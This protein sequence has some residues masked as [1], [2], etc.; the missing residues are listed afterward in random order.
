MVGVD[1]ALALTVEGGGALTLDEWEARS[2]TVA[3]GLA[4]GSRVGLLF[5]ARHWSD[6]AVAWLGVR[7][8]GAV[9]VLFSPGAAAPDLARAVAH[10]GLTRLIRAEEL[11]EIE[12]GR[13]RHIP[14]EV[15]ID[16]PD[17]VVYLLAPLAP[18]APVGVAG[19]AA[20]GGGLVHAWAPGSVGS[21]LA[22]RAMWAGEDVATLASFD[23]ERF[24]A[25]VEQRRPR[26]CGLTPALAAAVASSGAGAHH[27]L[28]SVREVV[29]VGRPKSA[30]GT[31]FPGVNITVLETDPPPPVQGAPVAVSQEGML[32]HE[33]FSPGS[34][35]LPCLVRRYRGALDVPA[36]E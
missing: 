18:P 2:D 19:G 32:W 25:L 1:A 16:P 3:G 12:R 24:C 26:R 4:A 23:P 11:E 31:V 14:G 36:L 10:A 22:L 34:F 8:A 6:F 33:Q 29:V 15:A 30:V 20:S 21:V 35:N 13:E 9:A 27:D 28:S 5:D 17:E 7:K